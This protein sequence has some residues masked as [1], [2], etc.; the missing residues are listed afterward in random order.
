MLHII[1]NRN[2]NAIYMIKKFK[3]YIIL[4]FYLRGSYKNQFSYS[5]QYFSYLN[6]SIQCL[7]LSRSRLRSRSLSL[8]LS[9]S[10]RLCRSLSLS[11]SLCE[12]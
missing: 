2:R 7:A 10:S 4:F 11:L 1:V 12:E 9:L 6:I 8:S 3:R 5:V